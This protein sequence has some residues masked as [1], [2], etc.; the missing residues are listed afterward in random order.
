MDSHRTI[1]D[2]ILK[3][4]QAELAEAKRIRSI[5]ELERMIADAPPPKSLAKSLAGRFGLIAEIKRMS[6]SGGLMPTKNV[7]K[8]PKL[9]SE[10]AV[11]FG[12]SVLTNKT[13]FGM[14]V[15]DLQN[16]R[17]LTPKPILRK[18]FI[19]D[20]YQVY[21]ARAFGADAILLMVNILEP[22]RLHMLFNLANELGM[23]VLFECHT[24]EQI[25][26]LPPQ[27][28]IIGINTR[29]F[30]KPV[31]LYQQAQARPPSSTSDP[32]TDL[33]KLELGRLLPSHAIKVAESGLHWSSIPAVRKLGIY[34]TLLV[35]TA[36]LRH[37]EG[38]EAALA[39]FEKAIHQT[40][41][42]I[43]CDSLW[44]KYGSLGPGD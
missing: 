29:Q 21:E 37:P 36:L 5:S 6:P 34:N 8:A 15:T 27:A 12:I 14:S 43:D 25:R 7:E 26:Q 11:V 20:E 10:S 13:Y 44:Q 1:L 28:K 30:D 22:P 38:I 9:Y 2:V 39:A 40:S 23:E 18:D 31:E 17:Q 16:I 19:I 24:A 42:Q 41:T 35:G 3:S 32:T 4:V 33:A